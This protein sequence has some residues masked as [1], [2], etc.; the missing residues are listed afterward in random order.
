MEKN[1][2]VNPIVTLLSLLAVMGLLCLVMFG[3]PTKGVQ[4]GSST[5][6]FP[7]INEFFVPEIEEDSLLKVEED[8]LEKKNVISIG[9]KQMDSDRRYKIGFF[10]LLGLFVVC[11]PCGCIFMAVS[12]CP[13]SG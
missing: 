2:N 4:I 9:G 10:I 1:N 11:L 8:Y 7:T 12:G 6:K 5:L 13:A 3:F